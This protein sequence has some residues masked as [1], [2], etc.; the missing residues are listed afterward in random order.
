MALKPGKGPSLTRF[1]GDAE[2]SLVTHGLVL[3]HVVPDQLE[4]R[5]ELQGREKPGVKNR[6]EDF[7][8]V[9]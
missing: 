3:L 8:P 2:P 9:P 4:G 5:E 1:D 7:L 6:E